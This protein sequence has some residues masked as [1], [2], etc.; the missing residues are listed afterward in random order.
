MFFIYWLVIKKYV[1]YKSIICPN[2]PQS[3]GAAL[4]ALSKYIYF[5]LSESAHKTDLFAVFVEL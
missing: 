5:K 3:S 1:Y 4:K 2:P